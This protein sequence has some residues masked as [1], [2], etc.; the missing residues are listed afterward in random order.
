MKNS[1]LKIFFIFIALWVPQ[2]LAVGSETASEHGD[3]AEGSNP[4]EVEL[5]DEEFVINGRESLFPHKAHSSR[6]TKNIYPLSKE[7]LKAGLDQFD[8]ESRMM[9]AAN[10]NLAL[11]KDVLK[12]Y[13]SKLP[14]LFESNRRLKTREEVIHASFED[15]IRVI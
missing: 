6:Q 13:I 3:S 2:T 14:T 1:L 12:K 4:V 9:Q 15:A 8:M 7:Q 5:S 10:W 11:K